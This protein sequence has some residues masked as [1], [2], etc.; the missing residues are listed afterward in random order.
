MSVYPEVSGDKTTFAVSDREPKWFSA[1]HRVPDGA[2]TLEAMQ[3]AHLTD[4]AVR[5]E[6]INFS[7]RTSLIRHEVQR[8]NPFDG[9]VDTI[10]DVGARYNIFQNEQAFLFAD[11]LLHGAGQWDALGAIKGGATVFGAMKLTDGLPGVRDEAI[12]R[13]LILHTSHDGSSNLSVSIVPIR[14]RCTNALGLTLK[15][16][17]QTF[18]VRHS[19]SM[20]GRVA[21]AREVLEL[22]D[23]YFDAFSASMAKLI[24]ETIT[25]NDAVKIVQAVHPLKSDA[26]NAVTRNDERIDAIMSIYNGP[27]CENVN[28]TRWGILNA[29]TEEL[30][31]YRRPQ[32]TKAGVENMDAAYMG[33][34]GTH[35][36]DKNRAFAIVSAF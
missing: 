30:D 15:G 12:G 32:N 31:W 10:G 13:Y 34:S 7:G 9:G 8:T 19:A 35:S 21:E 14:M 18:K 27:T 26:Q 29:I 17:K 6:P 16:A 33:L 3:A 20:S 11:E 4:W 24:D 1:G 2:S 23:I 25:I 36:A 22:S 5:L 28:G